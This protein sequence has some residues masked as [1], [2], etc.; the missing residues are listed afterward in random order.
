MRLRF[1]A[2]ALWIAALCGPAAAEITDVTLIDGRQPLAALVLPPHPHEDEEL[3]A[4]EL[5]EH[6]RR[7]SGVELPL[8]EGHAPGGLV[9]VRLGLELRP[10]AEQLIRTRSDDRAAFLLEVT[11]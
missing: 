6:L 2:T 7:M 3:A 1:A 8:V 9:P 11:G 10:E 4:R 5:R